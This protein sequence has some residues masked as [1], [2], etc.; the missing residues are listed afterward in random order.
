M[1]SS[2]ANPFFFFFAREDMKR[3]SKLLYRLRLPT[4][5]TYPFINS[6]MEEQSED[7]SPISSDEDSQWM[8]SQ[9]DEY[10]EL[11]EGSPVKLWKSARFRLVEVNW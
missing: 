5:P 11:V 6:T 1:L 8:D 3:L 7:V 4:N 2:D 9:P 10:I